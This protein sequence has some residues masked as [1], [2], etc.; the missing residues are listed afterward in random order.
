MTAERK[1][2]AM[3]ASAALCAA[4]L[5]ACGGGGGGSSAPSPSPSPSPAP[6]P[7][8]SLPD[9]STA[10]A[11]KTAFA[12]DFWVGAAIP[13]EFTTQAEAAVL[14]KHMNS[15]TAENAMKPDTIQPSLAGTPSEPA[16]LNFA[17]ADTIVAFAQ[18]NNIRMRGHTLL[19]HFTSPQW[20]FKGCDT[21]PAGCLPNVRVR[22]H[23]YIHNVMVH[24]GGKLYA[25]DV[26]NEVVAPNPASSTPYR[27]DS[28]WYITYQNA[29][30]AGANVQPWDYIEDAFRY[31]DEARTFLGLTSADMKLVINEYNTEIPGKRDNLV[32]IIQDLRNKGVPLDAVGH[33]MHLRIDANVSEVTAALV[34]IEGLGGLENQVTELD[35]NVYD[36][37][38][39]CGTSN[40]GCIPNYGSTPPQ[41]MLSREARLYRALYAAFKRPSVQS[42]TTWGLHDG[43]SWYNALPGARANYPLLFDAARQP[44]WA[45]WA[46]VDPNI[47]IP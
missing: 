30:N 2:R 47:T 31:A 7:T 15:L 17:P 28:P 42:V 27:T 19:W 3:G 11:L 20:F 43:W 37:P 34:A 44:K 33:Q 12:G 25:W 26:V 45:F 9:P 6:A 46:V 22:L 5:V 24:F 21:D 23:D 16:A 8:P 32:R 36:D 38:A 39:S 14:I 4:L 41:S 40:T 29:K 13:P 1:A 10:P 18:A 35:I